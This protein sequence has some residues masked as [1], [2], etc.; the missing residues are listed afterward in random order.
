MYQAFR[1]SESIKENQNYTDVLDT[2]MKSYLELFQNSLVP[3]Y[4]EEYSTTPC[5]YFSYKSQLIEL[6]DK[7]IC[8][9]QPQHLPQFV[10]S[11]KTNLNKSS[12]NSTSY[13]YEAVYNLIYHCAL[14]MSYVDFYH[15]WQH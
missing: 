4:E 8:V 13:R 9:L 7:L 15:A 14:K 3:E 6:S 10:K 11:L 2:M 1:Y 12:Y 5:Q